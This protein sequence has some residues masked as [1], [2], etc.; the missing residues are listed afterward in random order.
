MKPFFTQLLEISEH[1]NIYTQ[2]FYYAP[3]NN[4]R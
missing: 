4:V 1:A 2:E 3:K